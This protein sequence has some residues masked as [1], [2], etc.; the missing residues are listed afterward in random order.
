MVYDSHAATWHAALVALG[1]TICAYG[2]CQA[3]ASSDVVAPSWPAIASLS[4]ATFPTY[5]I[6]E[7]LVH[8]DQSFVVSGEFQR[9]T[10]LE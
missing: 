7:H 9:L 4:R 2:A 8:V 5:P 6:F 1:N 3:N 10:I